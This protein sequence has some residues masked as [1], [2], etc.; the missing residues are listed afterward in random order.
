MK[1]QNPLGFIRGSFNYMRIQFKLKH[2]FEKCLRNFFS[3][4]LIEENNAGSKESLSIIMNTE[5]LKHLPLKVLFDR[6]IDS[7]NF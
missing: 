4:V 3:F 1:R 5:A 7:F 2:N 6:N